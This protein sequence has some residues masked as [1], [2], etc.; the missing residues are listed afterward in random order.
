MNDPPTP[1]SRSSEPEDPLDEGEYFI[2]AIKSHRYRNL[3][4]WRGR[5]KHQAEWITQ[6]STLRKNN[7]Q[8]DRILESKLEFEIQ[9][10][11]YAEDETTW[12]P[13]RT[14]RCPGLEG[15]NLL[16]EYKEKHK[17]GVY[18]DSD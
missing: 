7:L 10:E 18:E 1:A 15:P 6:G 8:A 4:K 5:S 14:L 12:E 17:L 16:E 2:E 13:E 9:Y 11:G 3:V